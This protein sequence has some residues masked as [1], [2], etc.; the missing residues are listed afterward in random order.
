MSECNARVNIHSQAARRMTVRDT[1]EGVPVISGIDEIRRIRTTSDPQQWIIELGTN[2]ALWITS[3]AQAESMVRRVLAELG[4]VEEITWV[5]VHLVGWEEG[6]NWV[7]SAVEAEGITLVSWVE[8]HLLK[9]TA[10]PTTQGVDRL[11][12]VLCDHLSASPPP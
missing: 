7:N 10:H 12:E 1:F 8:P 3:Y 6:S 2:D 4:D 9:D 11:T 5:A